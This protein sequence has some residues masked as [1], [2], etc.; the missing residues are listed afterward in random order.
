METILDKAREAGLVL[1]RMPCN[2]RE[3]FQSIDGP[4]S[5]LQR[6]MRLRGASLADCKT[7]MLR[8]ERKERGRSTMRLIPRPG[9]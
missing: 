8:T 1:R 6:S 9:A 2:G 5:S 3:P 4:D 7:P